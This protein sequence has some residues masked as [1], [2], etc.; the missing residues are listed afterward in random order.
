MAAVDDAPEEVPSISRRAASSASKDD[1]DAGGG[2][3][4]TASRALRGKSLGD[5]GVECDS[6]ESKTINFKK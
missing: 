4:A 6:L 1:N 5:D 2:D 3:G